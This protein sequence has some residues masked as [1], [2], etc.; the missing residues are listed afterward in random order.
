MKKIKIEKLKNLRKVI[1]KLNAPRTFEFEG[2]TE[3]YESPFEFVIKERTDINEDKTPSIAIYDRNEEYNIDYEENMS[4]LLG[5][6]YEDDILP[7]LEN[8]IKKDLGNE[9]YIEHYD[10]VLMYIAY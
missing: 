2:E 4:C 10:S 3:T 6:H 5:H 7:Q 8:A 9:Y 1:D